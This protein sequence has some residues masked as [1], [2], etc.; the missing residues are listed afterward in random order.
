MKRKLKYRY[1]SIKL[2]LLNFELFI[3]FRFGSF[4]NCDIPLILRERCIPD[5][6]KAIKRESD[7]HVWHPHSIFVNP[8]VTI[9]DNC[10]LAGNNCI[11]NK[12]AGYPR[13]GN[14]VFIGVGAVI[15]GDIDIGDNVIVGANATVTKSV[16]DNCT[17]VQFNRLL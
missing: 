2:N 4:F 14:N 9:G 13:I 15:I 10:I 1:L 8:H 16:P 17:V 12:K 3:K 5:Y 7:I 6:K 11:G